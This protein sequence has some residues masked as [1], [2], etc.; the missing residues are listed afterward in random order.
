MPNLCPGEFPVRCS[1][2]KNNLL[3]VSIDSGKSLFEKYQEGYVKDIN[4]GNVKLKDESEAQ[5]IQYY[6]EAF[7][8]LPHKGFTLS[9]IVGARG[10][11]PL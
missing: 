8:K 6:A 4:L 9:R 10:R 11:S 7:L 2:L 1:P 5:H 3:Y